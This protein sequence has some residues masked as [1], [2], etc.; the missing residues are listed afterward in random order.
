MGNS[1]EE[2][3]E[4][5]IVH[6]HSFG[7]VLERLIQG[8]LEAEGVRVHSVS[9]RVKSKSSTLRKLRRSDEERALASLTDMLGIR[10]I[11]YFRDEVDLIAEI[12][13][14]EFRIDST[15]SVDKRATLDPDRFGYLS[16]HYVSQLNTERSRLAEYY[17]YKDIK[18]ELQIRS[19]LQHAWAEIEHDLG[20]KSEAAVPRTIRR[21]FSR[22]ASLLELADDEFVAIRE[23]LAEN[24]EA[25]QAAIDH[26]DLE[27][28][29]NQDSLFSFAVADRRVRDMDR[30]LAEL[31]R[32]QPPAYDVKDIKISLSD[33]LGLRA[34]RLAAAGF[35]SISELSRFLDTEAPLI[36]TF[37]AEWVS[38]PNA[39]AKEKAVAPIGI[40][41]FYITLLSQAQQYSE[42]KIKVNRLEFTKSSE[43]YITT[44]HNAV[45]KLVRSE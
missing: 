15:N 1:P 9:N 14:R 32:R 22:L 28:D 41:Y 25:S 37:A 24:K 17:T 40:T 13:E 43:R 44:L 16:L 11:T 6:L 20:Y 21:R 8:L 10:I 36:R 33:Y 3:Y 42:K 4:D 34:S 7:P 39:R 18:F 12:I 29:I 31:T 2:S 27:I 26:G 38:K 19:I 5:A 45:S 30:Y 35:T 23:G